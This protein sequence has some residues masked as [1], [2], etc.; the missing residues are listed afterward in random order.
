[1][2]Q[3]VNG[4]VSWTSNTQGAVFGSAYGQISNYIGGSNSACETW[5]IS[6]SM[7][8]TGGTSPTLSFQNAYNYAGTP[9]SV[10]VSTNYDGSSAPSTATWVQVSANLSTGAWNWVSSGD[11]SL[12]SFL[13]SNVHVAFKYVGTGTN[14]STWEID[15]ILIKD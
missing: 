6:P 5:L 13:S 11:I 9:L 7:N 15:D 12:L 2:V 1:S 3:M 8:L 14:G 10:W 4:S